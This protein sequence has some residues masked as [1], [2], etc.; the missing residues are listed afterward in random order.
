MRATVARDKKEQSDRLRA[1]LRRFMEFKDYSV[2]EWARNAGIAEGTLRNFLAGTS[3]TLTHATL[4][5]L[6]RAA[7][8]PIAAIIGEAPLEG[9]SDP[10]PVRYEVNA[11]TISTDSWMPAE[12][13]FDIYLPTDLRYPNARRFGAVVRDDSAHEFYRAGS[14]V[15]CINYVDID[16]IPTDGDRVLLIEHQYVR[17]TKSLIG[18]DG[19]FGVDDTVNH[20]RVT[21]REFSINNAGEK[22]FSFPA[23]YRTFKSTTLPMLTIIGDFNKDEGGY[24][25]YESD[26]TT[27]FVTTIQGLIIASYSLEEYRT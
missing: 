23:S 15:I 5:A 3:E 17:N 1:A 26:E 11:T 22:W 25:F 16:R 21:I 7:S 10:I 4:A 19:K 2:A 12:K 6:A 27:T 13:R 9:Y 18:D 14:I 24:C 8:Q 20:Y